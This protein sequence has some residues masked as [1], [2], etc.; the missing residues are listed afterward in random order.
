MA[1]AMLKSNFGKYSPGTVRED[2]GSI[3]AG[4]AVYYPFTSTT[5]S[6]RDVN[7]FE[8]ASISI[9]TSLLLFQQMRENV[10]QV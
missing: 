7:I 8:Y 2:R 6:S 10:K 4:L 3:S 9:K 1:A 5:S